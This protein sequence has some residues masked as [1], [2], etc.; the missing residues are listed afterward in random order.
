MC[1]AWSWERRTFSSQR[2]V[3]YLVLPF[4]NLPNIPNISN[5]AAR[6]QR[7]AKEGGQQPCARGGMRPGARTHGPAPDP[8]RGAPSPRRHAGWCAHAVDIWLW[9]TCGCVS[10]CR[11]RKASRRAARA[12]SLGG[13][14]RVVLARAEGAM[15]S[16]IATRG[17]RK[18]A[19]TIDRRAY[20]KLVAAGAEAARPRRRSC[21]PAPPKLPAR[22]A[23]AARPVFVF[24]MIQKDLRGTFSY[25]KTLTKC[26]NSR[27]RATNEALPV[28]AEA[29]RPAAKARACV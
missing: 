25:I 23:E 20:P 24:C 6:A 8:Q 15:P 27:R 26:V 7:V 11:W 21:P 3:A 19:A 16:R 5:R 14:L 29:A 1:E 4:N 12:G 10:V 13:Q 28:A 9:P 17:R 2:F 18:H 22:A